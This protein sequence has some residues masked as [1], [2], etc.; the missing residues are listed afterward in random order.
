MREIADADR[1]RRFM[2]SLGEEAGAET[3]VYLTGGASAVLIGWRDSTIDV[4]LKM[5]PEH[6]ALF[7]AIP[8]LKERLRINVE[9]A[10]P[11]DFIPLPAG[12][13]DRSPFISRE[14]PVSFH[15]FDFHAQALA[16]LE[17]HHTQDLQDVRQMVARGL[18]DPARVR[19]FFD[20][21]EPQLYRYPAVDPAS[22]R[23]AVREAFGTEEG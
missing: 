21:I 10:S 15:H 6:D 4:D 23:A 3:R 8:R 7:R 14:G 20:E 5:V 1:I 19:R 16:K 12:W 17:R 22:F 9:I 2:R 13:E 11:G 18:I